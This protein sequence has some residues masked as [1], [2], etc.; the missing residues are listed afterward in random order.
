MLK[1]LKSVGMLLF[2]SVLCGGKA[3]ASSGKS[4]PGVVTVQ[5][6][7]KCTGIVKDETGETVIGASVVVKGTAN[8]TIT[9]INGDFTL[10]RVAPGSTLV[11]SFLGYSPLEVKWTGAPLNILLKEDTQVLD[12]VVV[13]GYGTQKK[14]N[15]TG[16]VSMVGA[17]VIESR[18]VANV[19][20][21][22]QGVIPGL[23]LTTS[24]SGGDLNTSMNINIRGTGS[25]SSS[26]SPLILIDG[27]EGDLNLVNP[28]DIESVS[29]LKDAASASI[30]GSRA[31]FGVILVTTKSGKA[32]KVRVTYSGDVRFSTATQLPD[33]VD[34]YTFATYFNAANKNAG[35]GNYF[36]DEVMDKIQRYQRGEYTD[37]TQPEYYGTTAGTD[38]KWQEYGN[39]FANTD[40]FAE[41]YKK[42]VP[43]TQH[44]L[45]VSGGTEKLNWMVSG[46]FL[47]QNGLIRHG[48]DE[49]DRY[50]V[51][52]KIGAQLTDWLRL[53]YTNKWTRKDYTKPQYM[54]GLFFHNIAR[55]W[56]TCF[57]VD[58]NGHWAEG[59]EIAELEEGGTYNENN[60]LFTQQL[61]FT[62]EPL[63]NWRIYLEGSMRNTY[64]KTTEYDIPVYHYTV[65]NTPFLRDSGYGTETYVYDNRY[66]QNYYTVNVYTDYSRS[67][68]KHNG[69]VMAGLNF[70]H[71]DEDNLWATGTDL[72]TS[73]KPYLSQAQSNKRNGDGYW[74]RATAGYFGR[75]N[76]DYDGRY[77]F[78]FN[79]RY[80]GSSR[81]VGDQ[82][83]AW[84]PSVSLGWNM[85]REQ[86]FEKLSHR[87]SMLKLR[88]SW[89]QLG[90]TSSQYNTFI[91]W[92][93]FFQQQ[94]IGSANGSWLIDGERP[95]TSSLPSI[96]S[97]LLTWET[98][99]TWDAG[100]DWAALDNRLTGSFD[101]FSRTTKD[102]IGPAPTLGSALG[103]SAPQINNCDMRSTGWELEVGWRDQI[104]QVRYGA[105]VN[106][107]DSQQKI[108][109][110]PNE[111]GSL[112][113]YYDGMMLNN[114]WGYT[115]AGIASSQEEMDE[116]LAGN[117]PNWG[118]SW[119]AGDVMFKDLDGDGIVSNGDNTLDNH[120]DLTIIGNSTPRYRVGLNLDVAWKGIDFSVFFQGVMKRDWAF[121]QGDAYFWGA[122]GNVWQS[123]CFKEHL[124]YWTEDNLD[125]YY[126]KPYF[127]EIQKNQVIQT[128]YLQNA[129]YLRC[130]N[131]QLGYTL[132]QSWV[133]SAGIESCRIY[134]SCDNVFTITSLSD[135][136][137]P[138]AFG[139]YG[140][141][142]WG[143]G[144]TY[145]LQ[146]TVAVGLTLNF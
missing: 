107:S 139:G 143:S 76:Y 14:V 138:E 108:L 7:G 135:I 105:R 146:R 82:R 94:A 61:K 17:E 51:N 31:A 74:H 24:S 83:W 141:E 88:A 64:N 90:N 30:Y 130:K 110:Y 118:S 78:E 55:R 81:F 47:L 116:W 57:V 117:R 56:P 5:Q 91:D 92:Y 120:G 131:I 44:N 53:D 50:T 125:A 26:D 8:G 6:N 66:K 40:W 42:N 106:L 33:M 80:D 62:L 104:G 20:Q 77:L 71:Y 16:A 137:D 45:S 128:R 93:P 12:E 27:I 38:G 54:T 136:Y 35:S 41:F 109:T 140:D 32:G 67:F 21:A 95:N 115:S 18:P 25:I 133:R 23:N 1:H 89:G 123:A 9:G 144:K 75:L 59:M 100:F 126:P 122:T 39:A 36:S 79:I 145:P 13:V 124:D 98:V 15:V 34:S 3:Y 102:M 132:P 19:S 11:V 134:L 99:E 29:V 112:S 58:P 119:G 142:G 70:E 46:S 101:W 96:V 129:A 85:A 68:G 60:D 52:A 22:L 49:M 113:T 37:P 4:A 43:T 97:S 111:T 69:K 28:N 127:G 65:D 63:K 86:F 114:I 72:T 2:L 121:S 87:I 84:F 73:D 48:H 103:T 10:D